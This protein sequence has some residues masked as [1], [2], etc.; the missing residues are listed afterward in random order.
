MSPK[1]W[2]LM[3]QSDSGPCPK[4]AD[5]LVPSKRR[6]SLSQSGGGPGVSKVARTTVRPRPRYRQS[7]GG[8]CHKAA[9]ALI[10]PKQ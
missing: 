6:R 10:S 9:E 8:R 5:A 1:G 4:A 2:T 3:P 7:G